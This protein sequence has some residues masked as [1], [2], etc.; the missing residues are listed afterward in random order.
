[1][2]DLLDKIKEYI[3]YLAHNVKKVSPLKDDLD[4]I[5]ER[6]Y[7]KAFEILEKYN[8]IRYIEEEYEIDYKKPE[9]EILEDDP[10]IIGKYSD[11]ENEIIISKKSIE[12]EIDNQLKFLGY[13]EIKRSI[14]DI[15][16]I[17]YL[18]K[19]YNTILL[20][21][22]YIKEKDIRKDIAKFIIL[23]AMFHEI[24]HSID[25]SILNKPFKISIMFDEIWHSI[26]YMILNKLK[27]DSTIKGID[28]FTILKNLELR[29]SAFE[30]VMYYLANGFHKDEKVYIAAY[31]NISMCRKYVEEINILE[32]NDYM[33]ETVPYDLGYCYGNIIIAKYKSSLEENI[34]DIIDD[35]IHLDKEKAIDEIKL[36]GDNLEWI[37]QNK[38]F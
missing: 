18:Y 31:D 5:I 32:K 23:L 7:K 12:R 16:G 17:E 36:Y 34:H 10:S 3:K 14:S 11:F 37:L 8:I 9:L 28:Y 38:N 30:V 13:K 4:K 1:M 6:E 25:N 27:K 19:S 20:Y 21:P 33:E 15:Q 22:L 35:I 2:N 26:D 29:A 24:W